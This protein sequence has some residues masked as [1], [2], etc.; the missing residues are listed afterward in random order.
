MRLFCAFLLYCGTLH[1]A[2]PEP[3][4][5]GSSTTANSAPTDA[6]DIEGVVTFHGPKPKPLRDDAGGERDLIHVDPNNGGLRDVMVWLEVEKPSAADG[7]GDKVPSKLR[8]AIVDQRDHEFVP[9]VLGIRAGQAIR[10]TNS[11][12]ANHNVRTA[13]VNPGNQFNVF[14]GIDGSYRHRFDLEPQKQPI[15]VACDIHP[16]MRAW[17]YVFEHPFFTVTDEEGRFRIGSVPAGTYKVSF[18]QPDINYSVKRDV[19]IPAGGVAKVA[20]Q[21]A[22]KTD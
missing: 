18:Q 3:A 9:R 6:G 1:A 7:E 12:T 11:D 15:R 5:S 2:A 20:I 19:T 17:I 4:A 16:W 10:F 14:T 22:A 8:A 21:A 13:C